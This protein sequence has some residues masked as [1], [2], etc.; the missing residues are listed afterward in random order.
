MS[1]QQE[2]QQEKV[3]RF[4][5]RDLLQAKANGE[6]VDQHD[7]DVWRIE[8]ELIRSTLAYGCQYK[9][10]GVRAHNFMAPGHSLA[11]QAIEKIFEK[12]PDIDQ[13]D[14][15]VLLS[16]MRRIES[17]PMAGR[18]GTGWLQGL[19]SEEPVPVEWGLRSIV[20]DVKKN[21]RTRR[22]SSLFQALG[23]KV[24]RDTNFGELQSDYL[25]TAAEMNLE[26]A[27]DGA[28]FAPFSEYEW[29]AKSQIKNIVVP[30]GIEAI[31]QAAGGGHG[32]GEMM[33]VGGGTSHGKSYF[34]ERLIR[35]LREKRVR[36]AYLSFED[37]TDLMYCRTIADFSVDPKLSPKAIRTRRA[38]PMLVEKAKA[39]MRQCYGDG[40]FVMQLPK[41]KISD[42]ERIIYDLRYAHRVDVIIGD[43][44]QAITE[45][46]PM[47]NKVQEMSSITA[48]LKRAAMDTNTALVLLSQYSRESYKDGSEPNI[49]SFKYC[50]DIENEAEIVV[51]LWKDGDGVLH[52]KMPKVKWDRSQGRKYIINVDDRTGCHLLPWEDDFEPDKPAE[53]PRGAK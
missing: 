36:A 47:T 5:Y 20:E 46:E 9:G 18:R 33:V 7:L 17:N 22:W 39:A 44:I 28:T 1:E 19:Y 31:D 24:G 2:E 25:R 32:R 21:W 10:C 15:S 51:L 35:C 49:N 4:T 27:A 42:V 12:C 41:P 52:A 45:D 43:Y 30:T 53:Q 8:E 48:R 29:D 40:A 3:P 11:W 14:G 38:D 50:G 37:P 6:E 26:V 16:E 23:S 13:I 34:A